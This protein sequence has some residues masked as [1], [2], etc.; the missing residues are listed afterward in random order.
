[1]I[2]AASTSASGYSAG[3]CGHDSDEMSEVAQPKTQGLSTPVSAPQEPKSGS[4]GP[5]IF[6]ARPPSNR[7]QPKPT[8]RSFAQALRMTVACWGPRIEKN[9]REPSSAQ[10]DRFVL[11]RIWAESGDRTESPS[12]DCMP[13]A[14]VRNRY[15]TTLPLPRT[16]LTPLIVTNA[17]HSCRRA[18]NGST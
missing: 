10:D 16:V 14:L 4:W 12:P 17:S 18:T 7:K 11:L 3:R 2:T 8:A 5:R 1:M 6:R 15:A 9:A 13:L